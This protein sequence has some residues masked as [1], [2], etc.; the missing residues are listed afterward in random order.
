M[1]V[2]QY[3]SAHGSDPFLIGLICGSLATALVFLVRG[4]RKRVQNPF[5]P[6]PRAAATAPADPHPM[7][8]SKTVHFR[9]RING[10]D[11]ALSD[12]V[13]AAVLTA[14]RSGNEAE[15]ARLVQER[16]GIPAETAAKI[17]AALK[18]THLP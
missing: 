6:D 4:W 12:E 16:G 3:L 13:T 18:Q 14:L 9:V 17:A 8:L 1:S 2:S 11:H 5:A 10:E 15:A 7:T